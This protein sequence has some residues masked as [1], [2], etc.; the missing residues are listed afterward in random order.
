MRKALLLLEKYGFIKKQS[1][2]GVH[3]NNTYYLQTSINEEAMTEEASSMNE[4]L[5]FNECSSKL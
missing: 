5:N 3:G 4:E 2:H 1:R